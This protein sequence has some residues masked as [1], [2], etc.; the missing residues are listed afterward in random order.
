VTSVPRHDRNPYH[1]HHTGPEF[2]P[3][4]ADGGRTAQGSGRVYLPRLSVAR[5]SEGHSR[6][7]ERAAKGRVVQRA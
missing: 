3:R 1:R 4:E 6:G 7:I 5:R 2:R